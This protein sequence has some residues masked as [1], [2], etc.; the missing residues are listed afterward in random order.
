M[1]P[2]DERTAASRK[3]IWGIGIKWFPLARKWVFTSQNK[4]FVVKINLL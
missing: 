2:R 1:F 4:G 3:D